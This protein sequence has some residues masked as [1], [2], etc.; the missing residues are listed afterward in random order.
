MPDIIDPN[1]TQVKHE[2]HESNT[3]DTPA[4]RVQHECDKIL[5]LITTKV[6]TY[7]NTPILAIW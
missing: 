6:K 7:F 1:V 3:S 5:A 4:I 2:Q